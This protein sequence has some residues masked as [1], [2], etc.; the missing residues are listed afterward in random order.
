MR[1]TADFLP[2][3]ARS[4]PALVVSV[5]SRTVAVSILA[6]PRRGP[7]VFRI[8][9]PGRLRLILGDPRRFRRIDFEQRKERGS[10][11]RRGMPGAQQAI[12]KLVV[13]FEPPALERL[14]HFIKE[15][16]RAALFHLI[17][18][19]NR[20]AANAPFG[21]A[22][23]VLKLPDLTAFGESDRATCSSGAT[24]ASDAVDVIL[25]VLRQIVIEDHFE[26]IHVEST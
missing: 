8:L 2:A 22:H 14:A 25:G 5:V 18:S 21:K 1:G 10:D 20:F 26:V 23:D 4:G 3:S 11:V 13:F 9:S 15:D 19:R 17:R 16:A 24:R 6:L 12:D 7:V